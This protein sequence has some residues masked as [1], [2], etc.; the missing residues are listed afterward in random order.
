MNEAQAL[1]TATG[2]VGATVT[3]EHRDPATG[4]LVTDSVV[5]WNRPTPE[6]HPAL[7]IRVEFTNRQGLGRCAR[8]DVTELDAY[9]TQL[10]TKAGAVVTSLHSEA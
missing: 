3:H 9:L 4:E 10:I 5:T 6:P 2:S 1:A 8:V 7:T